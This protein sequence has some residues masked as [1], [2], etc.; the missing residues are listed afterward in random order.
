MISSRSLDELIPWIKPYVISFIAAGE[1]ALAEAFPE[2]RWKIGVTST[3]R[4]AEFQDMLYAKGRTEAGPKVTNAKG[5]DSW[6]NHRCAWDVAVLENGTTA[7]WDKKYYQILGRVAAE[8]GI[9]WG[10]DWNG[11]GVSQKEDFDLVHFQ[12]TGGLTLADLKAGQVP[13]ELA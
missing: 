11:D 1:L 5:G 4:D 6:H 8:L 2:V 12:M 9:T 3:F 10:G 13:K 7:T